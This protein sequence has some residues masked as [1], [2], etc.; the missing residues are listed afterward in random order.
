[1][2]SEF[3]DLSL[4]QK[5]VLVFRKKCIVCNKGALISTIALDAMACTVAKYRCS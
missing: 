5:I 4:S 2:V 3:S 1:M